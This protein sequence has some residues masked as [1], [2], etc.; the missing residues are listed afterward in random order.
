ME[1]HQPKNIR[2]DWSA[3]PMVFVERPRCPACGAYSHRRDRTVK[4]GD[5]SLTRHVRC[6]ACRSA[7]KIIV[8]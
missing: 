4:N 8:E 2:I 6:N 7:Y 5:E 3:V 1:A